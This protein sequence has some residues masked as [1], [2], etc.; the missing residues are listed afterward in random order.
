MESDVYTE[1]VKTLH[2]KFNSKIHDIFSAIKWTNSIS[3]L[4][5]L[6]I[7][8]EAKLGDFDEAMRRNNINHQG[9]ARF[10]E[11]FKAAKTLPENNYFLLG[12]KGKEFRFSA[13]E[14]YEGLR[15]SLGN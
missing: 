9:V 11:L 1:E 3:Y 12:Y 15:S 8:L 10:K 2:S 14:V 6:D 7:Y 4:K 13:K 5:I